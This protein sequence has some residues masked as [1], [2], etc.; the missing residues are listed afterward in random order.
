MH[1]GHWF[2][3]IDEIPDSHDETGDNDKGEHGNG[4]ESVALHRSTMPSE[5]PHHSACLASKDVT[6]HNGRVQVLVVED[7]PGLRDFLRGGLEAEGYSVLTAH[8]GPTGLSIARTADVACVV[9][10]LGLPGMSGEEVLVQLR[11]VRPTL[12]V[13]VL[14]ARDG[15]HD[16]VRNLDAGADDYMVKPFSLAELTARIRARLRTPTQ[17]AASLLEVGAVRLDLRRRIAEVDSR[18]VHLTTREFGLVETFM[19]HPGH[20]LSQQQLLAQV[21]G[22]YFESVSSNVVEVAVRSIRRKLGEGVV[23]TVRGAGYRFVG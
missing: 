8:D 23:E 16:R 3:G 4:G 15:I 1:R 19:R 13:I 9:L 10:D 6:V 18:D 22:Q 7:E 5:R 20:V 14:T 11:S 17:E 21:W 2:L 12:P